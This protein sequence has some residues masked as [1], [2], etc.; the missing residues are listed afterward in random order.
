MEKKTCFE[1]LSIFTVSHFTFTFN[2]RVRSKKTLFKMADVLLLVHLHLVFSFEM[3]ADMHSCLG[4][5]P[6]V[7]GTG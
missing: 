3:C 4:L 7:K 6:I 1:L 5:V 2:L